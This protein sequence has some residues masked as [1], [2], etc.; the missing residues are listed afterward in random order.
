MALLLE[1]IRE[2]KENKGQRPLSRKLKKWSP[3]P[4]FAKEMVTDP[5]ICLNWKLLWRELINSTG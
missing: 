2:N 3:T 5:I 1:E 4:L